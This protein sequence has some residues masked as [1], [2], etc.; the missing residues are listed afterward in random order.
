MK[1]L[2]LI[3]V[4]SLP[5]FGQDEPKAQD[6]PAAQL[7]PAAVRELIHQWVQTEGLISEEKNTWQVERQ[8]MQDLLGLFQKELALLDDEMNQAG[9]SAELVDASKQ[10][11]E[12]QI[13]EY[14][15]AQRT[16]DEYL[17]RVLPRT[18]TLLKRLPEPLKNNLETDIELLESDEALGKPRE[19]LKSILS[20]FAA[21]GRFNR[22]ITVTEETR[23]L[24]SG[25]KMTVDVLYLGLARAFYAAEQGD[26][27]GLGTP[28]KDGWQWQD[29]PALADSV[30]KAFA[31]Y[32]KDS[33][34]QLV[35]LPIQLSKDSNANNK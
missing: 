16:L 24:A 8:R 27:A 6:D 7:D 3:T 4:I 18:R 22:T 33:P 34:P 20:V 23:V 5:L 32:R 35:E 28:G 29:Q 14:R 26:T 13:S 11:L 30:R 1:Y 19:T 25:K 2:A 9:K 17:A 21:C 31:V 15:A 12:K 10:Q